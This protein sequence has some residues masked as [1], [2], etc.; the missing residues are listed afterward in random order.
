MDVLNDTG[1]AV[2]NTA[3]GYGIEAEP[4]ALDWRILT[5]A[6][7]G[8]NVFYGGVLTMHAGGTKIDVTAGR[9]Q[10]DGVEVSWAASTNT[11]TPTAADATNPRIDIVTVDSSGTIAIVNGTAA[12]QAC[13]PA[14][15][16]NTFGTLARI[17]LGAF[18]TIGDGATTFT[19]AANLVDKRALSRNRPAGSGWCCD[20]NT[21][22]VTTTGTAGTA[23]AST[24]TNGALGTSAV[25]TVSSATDYSRRYRKGTRLR[26]YESGSEK[27]GTVKSVS[28]S[29]STTTV[30]LFANSTHQMTIGAIDTGAVFY[31]HEVAPE[32]YPTWWTFNASYGGM[33]STGYNT[34]FYRFAV[35][36]N[37]IFVHHVSGGDFTSNATTKT[38]DAPATCLTLT[39]NPGSPMHFATKDNGT[40]LTTPGYARIVTNTAT[41]DMFKDQ[42]AAAWTNSGAWRG[43]F[44][45]WYEF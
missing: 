29:A 17:V 16:Y 25:F 40:I 35:V 23:S 24:S 26:W 31:S 3:T 15:T 30:T 44:H 1:C 21:W 41:I 43:D 20:D 36:G 6:L 33:S 37:Q 22:T 8:T 14:L 28:F 9:G 13:A 4:D 10:I 32:G 45:F 18:Y 38:V 34:A 2:L 39:G 11:L 5:A 27:F 7:C 19:T 42:S 12:A